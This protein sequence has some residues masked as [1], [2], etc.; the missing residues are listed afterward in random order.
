MPVVLFL[1]LEL[2]FS[3]SVEKKM[4]AEKG[5][6]VMLGHFARL[7]FLLSNELFCE[8]FSITG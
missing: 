2:S 6:F 8:G 3:C 5:K 7:L 1:S 4:F